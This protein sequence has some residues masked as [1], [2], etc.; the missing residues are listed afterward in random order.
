MTFQP[1]TVVSNQH[2]D[3]FKVAKVIFTL[4]LANLMKFTQTTFSKKKI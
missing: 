2:L 4:F 1:E 3:K